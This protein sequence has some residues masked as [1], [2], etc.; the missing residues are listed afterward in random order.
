MPKRILVLLVGSADTKETDAYQVLQEESAIA[1]AK[2]AGV[3][4]EIVFAPGFD[5]LRVVRRRM[6]DTAAPALDAVIVEPGSVSSTGLI[7]KELKGRAGL[8]LLNAWSPEVD[9]YARSWGAGLPFGTLSTDHVQLGSI[10]G[11]QANAMLARGRASPRRDRAATVVGRRRAPGRA[12]RGAAPRRDLLRNPLRRMDRAGRRRRVR[13]LVRPLQG[14][15]LPRGRDRGPE[16]RAGGGGPRGGG[17]GGEP[18]PS[19]DLP[20]GEGARRRRLSRV[21]AKAR[22]LRPAHRAA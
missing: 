20:E 6:S 19:R 3:I 15:H 21:R 4:A 1:E 17:G 8:V 14:P 13:Q 22:R 18:R 10:Q 12:A 2:S 5:Q 9:E 7:L 16:R 11:R